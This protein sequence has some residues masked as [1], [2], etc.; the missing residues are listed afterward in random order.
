MTFSPVEYHKD[1]QTEVADSAAE[2]VWLE[3]NGWS[4]GEPLPDP[5]P[6]PFPQYIKE[7]EKA[8]PLGVATLDADGNL[9]QDIH[10]AQ[11]IDPPA[12]GGGGGDETVISIVDDHGAVGDDSTNNTVAIQAALNAAGALGGAT[13]FVPPGVFRTGALT[14][15]SRVRLVGAGFQSILRAVSGAG[16][17]L[18]TAA[19]STDLVT[20]SN[21]MLSCWDQTAGG[22][23]M[24]INLTS[25]SAGY[26]SGYPDAHHTIS[27]VL[28]VGTAG[29]GV[30]LVANCREV[31]MYNVAVRDPRAGHGFNIDGTD[32]FF[33]SCTAATTRTPYH[34]WNVHGSNNRLVGCKAFYC[35][36]VGE[37]SDGFFLDRGRNELTGCEAQDNGRN[38]FYFASGGKLNTATGIVADSNGATGIKVDAVNGISLAGFCTFS[39]SGG[40]YPQPTGIEFVGNPVGGS[41]IGVSRENT[42]ADVVGAPE[43]ATVLITNDTGPKLQRVV[44]S[45]LEMEGGPLV[46]RQGTYNTPATIVGAELISKDAS[47]NVTPSNVDLRMGFKDTAG[48]VA[49]YGAL[50]AIRGADFAASVGLKVVTMRTSAERDAAYFRPS[51]GM[52]LYDAADTPVA[53]AT[54]GTLY[55]SAGGLKWVS[56]SG[57]INIAGTGLPFT[58]YVAANDAPA[59]EKARAD[60]VCDGVND[61]VQIQ[62]AIGDVRTTGGGVVL[63]SQG[64]FVIG[65]TIFVNGD[66]DV[67]TSPTIAIRGAGNYS[68]QLSADASGVTIFDISQ[69]ARVHISDM[70]FYLSGAGHAIFTH[71]VD[72]GLYWR[73]V[74]ESVFE[75]LWINGGYFNHTGWAMKLGSLFRSTVRDIHIEGAGNGIDLYAEHAEQN[76]GDCIFQRMMVGIYGNSGVAYHIGSSMASMNQITFDTCHSFA[77]PEATFTIA[78]KLDGAVGSNHII[79][80]NCNSEQFGKIWRQD[81]GFGARVQFDHVTLKNGATLLDLKAD[82]YW[83]TFDVGDI[84]VEESAAVTV[85]ADLNTN[86]TA[87]NQYSFHGWAETGSVCTA[88]FGPCGYLVSSALTGASGA[89]PQS[90]RKSPA[91]LVPRI[92]GLTDTA[93]IVTDV[94]LGNHFRV[95][96]AGNRTLAAPS[97][98]KDGQKCVWELT[99]DASARTVTLTT[100]TGGFKLPTGITISATAANTTD[101]IEAVYNETANIWRVLT[102]AKAF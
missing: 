85:V 16:T 83:S 17:L 3:Y 77:R 55:S 35:G 40:R 49:R 69:I 23:A 39:R 56:S 28:I 66:G 72:D 33:T 37:A 6:D 101:I 12:G 67:D 57:T 86:L 42:V 96:M 87:P 32:N 58:K 94:Q 60:Y 25:N 74:D 76:P 44:G 10:Y 27:D 61:E 95:T 8:A 98:P 73:S 92:V 46:S 29:H 9:A 80:R 102:Y 62:N 26:S 59:T 90:L 36:L 50:R 18:S 63:L 2:A 34:G 24:G 41:F 19:T 70:G 31:R 79:V 93:S 43:K 78:W 22:G 91:I 45:S 99:A 13:V 51:G 64:T 11:I 15:P 68:T 38:G 100:S 81:T 30:Q 14:I 53:P 75:R 54:G 5:G 47:N 20:I 82:A 7:A 4:R 1:D 97:N 84:Y 21:L 71:A 52:E 89:V 65:A 48:A 88:D